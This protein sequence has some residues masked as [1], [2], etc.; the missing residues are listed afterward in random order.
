ML[1]AV[2]APA[3]AAQT[4][5]AASSFGGLVEVNVV[6]VD[7]YVTDRDGSR[8]TGLKKEDFALFEDGKPVEITNFTA[9][10]GPPAGVPSQGTAAEAPEVAAAPLPAATPDTWLNL[11]V[12]VDNRHLRPENRTRAL[13]Q[14]RQFL[15]RTLRRNDRV[16]LATYDLDLTVR[17]TFTEDAA[18]L[19]AALR[20]M[21]T[22]ASFGLQ[23]DQSRRSALRTMFALHELEPC[24][25]DMVKPVEGYAE[26]TR[27]EARLTIEAL[28]VL[29]N[30]LAGIPG[31]KAVLYVSDGVPVT[32]G[33]ELFQVVFELC[34]GGAATS[35]L[36]GAA[37]GRESRLGDYPQYPAQQ[38]LLDAQKYSVAKQ[39]EDLAD[40][41][42]AN[43]VTL[44][45][46]Q[47]SGLRNGSAEADMEP[48]ERV[49]QLMTVQ[50]VQRTNLQSSLTAMAADTGGRAMIDANDFLPDLGRM[51]DDFTNYYSLG[52][53]PA[54][55]GDGRQHRLEV[56][57]K[58]A[59][60]RVR[61]RQSFRDKPLIE[62]T[63]DR[64]LAALL[65]GI[66]DNPLEVAVE[67]GGI[68]RGPAG[69]Y[70]VPVRLKVPLH[71]LGILNEQ[72]SYRGSLRLLVATSNPQ[73]GT[74]PVRQVA[75]PIQ[76]PRQKVLR[77]MGQF[78]LYTL[79][80]EM[81]PGE[82]R[83]AVAVRDEIA[84]TT[85]YLSRAVNVGTT[86]AVAKPPS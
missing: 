7:V 83:I 39:F 20:Q 1:T 29:V 76:I 43:R 28:K 37:P 58:K 67:I 23:A 77:I 10:A 69:R 70:A 85:S 59:G 34:G 6:N 72:G 82:Q 48:G 11:A 71:K 30:S 46:L 75:V 57:V 63:V 78:Y 55:A 32:P 53:S 45:T 47:A 56:K 73:G 8:V 33:E 49:L 4:P 14:I 19:G 26:E 44:Y 68:T 51:H 27:A 42:N 5:P 80:L 3:L 41:A 64:M 25:Y 36:P 38:A 22:L 12:L 65:H 54:H 86:A 18:A 79:T 35:G 66:E 13:E 24:S 50:Q 74:S 15:A 40:H 52:Y 17:Q 62:R 81:P 21:E 9:V 61:Y 60:L 16:M 84:A 31:R 2:L